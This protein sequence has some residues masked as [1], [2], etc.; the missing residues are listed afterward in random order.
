MKSRK[1]FG[2][3]IGVA[4]ILLGFV[5]AAHAGPPL[6]CHP[7]EIGSAH[8]LPLISWN[9]PGNGGYDTANLTR[10]TVAILDANPAVLVRM[11]TLRRATIFARHDP[12]AAAELLNALRTRAQKSNALASFDLGYLTEG[13]KQWMGKDQVNPAADVDGYALVQ[14]AITQRGQDAEMEFAAALIRLSGP[15]NERR[16]HAQRAM[17]GAKGDPLLA[18]NLAADFHGQVLSDLMI[19]AT[20]AK[21]SK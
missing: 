17:A 6:I 15:E 16:D 13:Y 5:T 21:L 1:S 9:E 20:T 3:A 12:R 7:L 10:D 2:L 19:T 8:S 14:K 18:K 4:T 11:E